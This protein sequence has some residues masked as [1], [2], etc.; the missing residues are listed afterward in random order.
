MLNDKYDLAL[1]ATRS[2]PAP[3]PTN[4]FRALHTACFR[5]ALKRAAVPGDVGPQTGR[6]VGCVEQSAFGGVGGVGPALCS[7][8]GYML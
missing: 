1:C 5:A 6:T 7:G 2:S 4:G 3:A 8:W